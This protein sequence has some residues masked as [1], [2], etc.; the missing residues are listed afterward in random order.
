MVKNNFDYIDVEKDKNNSEIYMITCPLNKK[1]IGT[2][3]M[4]LSN[5]RKAGHLQRWL[6]HVSEAKNNKNFCVALDESIR[7]HNGIGFDVKV[8]EV[9]PTDKREE[10]EQHYIK[11]YNTLVPNGYNMTQGGRDGKRSEITRQ[12]II[13]ANTG[14]NKGRVYNKQERKYEGDSELPKYVSSI[15]NKEGKLSGYRLDKHPWQ[16]YIKQT[17][18][19]CKNIKIPS[20]ALERVLEKLEEYDKLYDALPKEQIDSLNGKTKQF[21]IKDNKPIEKSDNNKPKSLPTNR[22]QIKLTL[23]SDNES[24]DEIKPSRKINSKIDKDFAKDMRSARSKLH[25][26]KDEPVN[27]TK[28]STIIKP[29][30]LTRK[31][32]KQI[33]SD[34]SNNDTK[35]SKTKS[36]TNKLDEL[37]DNTDNETKP[38]LKTKTKSLIKKLDEQENNSDNEIKS[39]TKTKSL[40]KKLDELEDNTDNETKPTLKPKLNQHH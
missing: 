10:R 35:S 25:E 1:Y 21:I 31:S 16:K 23:D 39:K 15:H 30:S 12:N 34:V 26:P 40:I 13:I 14:K 27:E 7:R 9:C 6:A 8:L 2:C 36:L 32:I 24:D 28:S 22:Q 4:V 38:I 19:V 20:E 37:E 29:V 33:K 18:V 3:R 11:H 5:E 17:G